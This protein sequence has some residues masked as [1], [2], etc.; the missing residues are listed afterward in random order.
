MQTR[1]LKNV[2]TT[3]VAGAL[4]IFAAGCDDPLEPEEHPEAGGVVILEEGTG[5]VLATS[6]GAN[7]AFDNPI[8]VPL[9]GLLEVEVLFLNEDDP[10]DLARAFLPD[11]DE[12]ESL[13][14]TIVN[15]A[16]VG[17]E[18]HGDHGDFEGL[19]VGTTTAGFDLMHGGHSDFKSG[20]LTINVQ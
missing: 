7:T 13:Q 15:E 20:N 10:T 14:V 2:A 9:G 6:I 11:E 16:I 18:F 1:L 12:G 3:I 19:A 4:A 17:F 8:T 5:T